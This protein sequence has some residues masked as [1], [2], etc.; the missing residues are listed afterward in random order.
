MFLRSMQVTCPPVRSERGP[1]SSEWFSINPGIIV[2]ICM[3]LPRRAIQLSPFTF[4]LTAFLIP[5]HWLKGSGFKKGVCAQ[6]LTPWLPHLGVS[7][8]WLPFPE[9]PRLPSL[10]LYPLFGLIV[11]LSWMP[12]PGDS[13]QWNVVGCYNGSSSFPP[14]EHPSLL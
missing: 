6:L 14:I 13:F 7:L 8:V 12:L 1:T 4:T 5:Y 9:R 10:A 3:P 11:T 2:L